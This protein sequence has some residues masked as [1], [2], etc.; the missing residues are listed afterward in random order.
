[1]VVAKYQDIV[2]SL[3]TEIVMIMNFNVTIFLVY[4]IEIYAL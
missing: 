1:M 4:L 3:L 2:F